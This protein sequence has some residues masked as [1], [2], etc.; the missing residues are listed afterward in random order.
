MDK[1]KTFIIGVVFFGIIWATS[2]N[3]TMYKLEAT[4]TEIS[5]ET[6]GTIIIVFTDK[7][8]NN[9]EW[10]KEPNETYYIGDK[11]ELKMFNHCT[12]ENIYDDEIKK[13]K[14]IKKK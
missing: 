12:D 9:W 10:E 8:G 3:E 5:T 14:I 7:V 13:I 11:V 4:V 2:Y 1:I 6:D